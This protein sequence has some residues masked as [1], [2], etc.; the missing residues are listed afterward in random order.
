MNNASQPI[1][2]LTIDDEYFIRTS[3]RNFLEDFD[4]DVHE[5]SNGREGL[6]LYRKI[7]PDIIL[8]DLRMPEIDGLDVLKQITQEDSHL[9]VI[10]ISGTGVISDVIEAL[11]LGAWDYLLK[12]IEDLNVLLHAIEKALERARLLAENAAYQEKLET[13]VQERTKDLQASVDKYQKLAEHLSD[14][15]LAID[16]RGF[17]TYCSPAIE[18]LSGFEAAFFMGKH[19]AEFISD[20]GE[21]NYLEQFSDDEN[22]IIHPVVFEVTVHAKDYRTL[23]GELSLQP[24]FTGNEVTSYQCV[25]RDISERK[26][27]DEEKERMAAHL[28]H[29][30]KME[31]L[32]QLAGGIAHDLNNLL[33]PIICYAELVQ[34]TLPSEDERASDLHEIHKAATRAKELIRKLITFSTKQDAEMKALNL[35]NVIRELQPVIQ[36]MTPDNVEIKLL[37]NPYIFDV[38]ADAPLLDQVIMN[39]MSNALDAISNGGQITLSTAN[40]AI[41]H[42][43]ENGLPLEDGNYVLF[44]FHDSGHGISPEALKH[45]FEPFFTTKEVGKGTGLGLST[46]FGIIQQFRG[47]ITVHSQSGKGTTFRMYLPK[48]TPRV[49]RETIREK[50]THSVTKLISVLLV[51]DD[52]PSRIVYEKLLCNAGYNVFTANDAEH[53]ISMVNDEPQ[54]YNLIISDVHLPGMNGFDMV[55]I[56]RKKN[57]DLQELFISGFL[58]E[59][60]REKFDVADDAQFLTKPISAKTLINKV[61]LMCHR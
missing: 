30:Q 13:L 1:K 29:I 9:P 15:V 8:V 51:E 50:I 49:Q 36:R 26:K 7:K 22:K 19:I 41:K 2:V 11:H 55:K 17:V 48:Y 40:I 37:L 34:D 23:A 6:M 44:E 54:S 52:D 31:S 5:A 4:Y 35:N 18:P 38:Y 33:T 28:L 58:P 21:N 53:A 43:G 39:L 42:D 10:V 56:I 12:P 14:V 27:A 46:V 61:N 57:P 25:L 45:V 24:I 32:G 59:E 20:T 60:L 47:H 16:M 3:I